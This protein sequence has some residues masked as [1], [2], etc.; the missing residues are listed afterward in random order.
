MGWTSVCVPPDVVSAKLSPRRLI[1]WADTISNPSQSSH[2]PQEPRPCP[3]CRPQPILAALS[4][5]RSTQ[6]LH[7]GAS[8]LNLQAELPDVL[9]TWSLQLAAKYAPLA[10]KHHFI[11]LLPTPRWRRLVGEEQHKQNHH[12]ATTDLLNYDW[13]FCKASV[14]THKER[15][16]TLINASVTQI[17]SLLTG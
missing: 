8:L 14:N 13:V 4:V 12:A 11:K 16:H 7:R 3:C 10:H 17:A 9:L 15:M 2:P 5:N 1:T 6:W